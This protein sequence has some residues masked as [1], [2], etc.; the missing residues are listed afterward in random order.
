M[1]ERVCNV[2]EH[3]MMARKLF[4][5]AVRVWTRIFFKMYTST[6]IYHK[7]TNRPA[8]CVSSH[9]VLMQEGGNVELLKGSVISVLRYLLKPHPVQT[10][11]S[12]QFVLSVMMMIAWKYIPFER[13]NKYKG[14]SF[15]SSRRTHQLHFD[16]NHEVDL[17]FRTHLLD[18]LDQGS[19]PCWSTRQT[20]GT[21]GVKR[22]QYGLPSV[23]LVC[24][25]SIHDFAGSGSLGYIRTLSVAIF[26]ISFD[27]K[28]E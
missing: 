18:C 27:S 7:I 14:K 9:V 8:A 22:G 16:N 1:K 11:L 26:S 3:I 6:S 15:P 5:F 24:V 2:R 19:V 17:S 23:P 28:Y 13:V 10:I 20:N 21:L 25:C 4:K 12:L